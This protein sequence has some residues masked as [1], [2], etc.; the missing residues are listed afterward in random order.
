M[1]YE[2]A[3]KYASRYGGMELLEGHPMSTSDQLEYVPFDKARVPYKSQVR[4][5]G[6]SYEFGFWYNSRRDFFTVDLFRDGLLV[7][8]GEPIVYNQPLFQSVWSEFHPNVAIIPFGV[9]GAHFR[10]GWNEM[11]NDVQ[12]YIIDPREV[13]R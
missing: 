7:T 11:G 3:L 9:S 8:E 13:P 2:E 12:L 6:I 1:S 5:Q 4:I 10:V